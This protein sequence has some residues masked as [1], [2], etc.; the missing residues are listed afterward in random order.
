[1]F[2]PLEA[3]EGIGVNVTPLQTFIARLSLRTGL[4]YWQTYNRDVYKDVTDEDSP[5]DTVVFQRV[6]DSFPQGLEMAV[7]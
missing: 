3:K 6:K 7:I 5:G 2:F 4:G 1:M